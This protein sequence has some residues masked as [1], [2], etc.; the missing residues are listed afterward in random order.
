MTSAF[1]QPLF[2]YKPGVLHVFHHVEK[3]NGVTFCTFQGW[4]VTCPDHVQGRAQAEEEE[5]GGAEGSGL[6]AS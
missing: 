6:D 4:S 2:N 3:F 5:V 1:S